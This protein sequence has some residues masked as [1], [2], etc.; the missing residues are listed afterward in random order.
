MDKRCALAH[1]PVLDSGNE[2]VVEPF[3]NLL[4]AI[5]Y[6]VSASERKRRL[7]LGPKR[8]R[9]MPGGEF[10]DVARYTGHCP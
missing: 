9:H 10:A 1:F 3:A 6:C 5:C 2:L 8:H 7:P 4:S